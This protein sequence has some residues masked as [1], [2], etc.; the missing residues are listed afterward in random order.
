MR[1]Q[2]RTTAIPSAP[3]PTPI[4]PKK[5][6]AVYTRKSTDEGLDQEYNSLEAQRDA[7]LAYI[8]SQRHEGWIAVGDGYD[9]GGYSGGNMDRPALR[10]LLADIEAGKIDIV[11][12]YKI[13]RL[14]RSLPD[15]AKLVEVFD[16][17]GVSFVSVTQQFNTTT[18]M[19]RLTL[20]ILLSFAQFE[21]EVTGER[22]R[23]KIA[24]SKAKGMW[25]GG[26]PPLGYDVV[27]RKLVINEREAA[28]VRD[29][30]RRYAEHGSAA[31]L[32]RELAVEGHTT[33]SWVTQGGRHRTG[34]PIDQQYIF[35]L[36]RNRIYLGE[37][38]NN[39]QRFRGQ[40]EPIVPQDLWDAAHAFIERRKQAP[41][42]HRAKHPALLAGL[43]FAPD[44]Q[45]ML[46]TFV[47]KKN[48]RQYRYY[49][50][51]LHKRRNAGAT[52]S[53]GAPDVG[54]LP[55]A[56]IEN[57]VLAQIHAA[58]SAPEVLIGT[59]RACQRH[60]AGAALDEAQVVVAMRRIGAVW[61]QL[62]PAE[63]QRIVRLLVERVQLH[64]QG[65]DIIWREDG[66][67]GLG[68]DI[69]AHPLIDEFREE[70]EEAMA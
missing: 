6:C 30:F 58:L 42:E 23:D 48:G 47:K 2:R 59:W 43:L 32:V 52:L 21:R 51:Y 26:M 44:G 28:L 63:Q 20:N 49:V 70:V 5:R 37:L 69:G 1:S 55:A 54:H 8:A 12:V 3:T 41:R 13:D 17:N 11:V 29:I 40:H 60:P 9:D 19:G 10:R 33:K 45:R 38:S 64:E 57:A 62:F 53:P 4:T 27:E 16:R 25:M 39:G 65:L 36:L 24:A 18:S 35:A 31:Q 66:W 22:I 50:P 7:G 67:L 56:E 46:H 15:F 34:R 61:E 14:T 68:P